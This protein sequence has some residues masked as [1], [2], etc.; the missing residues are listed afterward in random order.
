MSP[1]EP[2][3][4][5]TSPQNEKEWRSSAKDEFDPKTSSFTDEFE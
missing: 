3:P 4:T 5:P 1:L 2:T